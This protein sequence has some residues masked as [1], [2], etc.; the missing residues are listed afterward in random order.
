ML[1]SSSSKTLVKSFSIMIEVFL[2]TLK[3]IL[4]AITELAMAADVHRAQGSL[5]EESNYKNELEQ[6]VHS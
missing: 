5:P 2:A 6:R 3:Y 4:A 1:V